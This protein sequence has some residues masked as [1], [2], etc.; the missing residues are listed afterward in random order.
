MNVVDLRRCLESW[1]YDAEQ[2]VRMGRGADGRE[3][4]LVRHPM[5][6]EQY[7]ADGRPDGRRVHGLETVLDF[8]HARL[9]A[10]KLAGAAIVFALTAEDCAELFHEATA[11]HHRL[12]VLFRLQDWPRAERDAAQN[13]RLLE[14]EAA[15][16]V[17][18]RV[19]SVSAEARP[20]LLEQMARVTGQRHVIP[21][22]R[23]AEQ[24]GLREPCGSDG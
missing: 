10:A 14:F 8:H 21:G 7:E 11:Y 5:G 18:K 24:I 16:C 9:E 22:G 12:I 3:I 17:A 15:S 19:H 20:C 13:L 1:P 2:N 6:L 4:I 23:H